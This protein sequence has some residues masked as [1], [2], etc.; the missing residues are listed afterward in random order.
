[1]LI[2]L[3]GNAVVSIHK[4]C[5]STYKKDKFLTKAPDL[6]W[7]DNI[8][9]AYCFENISEALEFEEQNHVQDFI[10]NEKQLLIWTDTG[11]SIYD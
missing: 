4:I 10:G 5:I 11:K 3:N 6:K 2:D 9:F 8:E 1:M 7:T